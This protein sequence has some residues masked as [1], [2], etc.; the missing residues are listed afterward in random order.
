M[1]L[2]RSLKHINAQHNTYRDDRFSL[3]I[4]ET[5]ELLL[6][7]PNMGQC[8]GASHHRYLIHNTS[9]QN[10]RDHEHE[11]GMGSQLLEESNNFFA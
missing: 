6:L 11:E 9:T 8:H 3:H 1:L 7:L 5:N 10:L 2:V 4:L